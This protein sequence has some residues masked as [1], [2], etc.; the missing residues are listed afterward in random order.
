V[1][2]ISLHDLEEH[3]YQ[4][5]DEVG[6]EG[7]TYLIKTERGNVVLMPAD[8]YDTLTTIYQDWLNETGASDF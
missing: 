4:I 3:F 5:L 2:V 1:K 8:E 7:Q 6:D